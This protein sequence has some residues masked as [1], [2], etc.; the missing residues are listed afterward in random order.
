MLLLMLMMHLIGI[1]INIS[2]SYPLGLYM[3][4]SGEYERGSLVETCVPEHVSTMMVD[5]GYIPDIGSC[6][7]YPPFIKQVYGVGGDEVLVGSQV[8]INGIAIVGTELKTM[9]N[10][11]REYP[12]AQSATV[13]EGHVWLM[14]N[15]HPDSY[16]SRYF[17]SIPDTHILSMLRPLWTGK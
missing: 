17:G 12:Q 14:S 16:D 13:P 5:R 9:D 2:E 3:K 15:N 1:R 10:E 11:Q 4:V 6:G 7:N 8:S